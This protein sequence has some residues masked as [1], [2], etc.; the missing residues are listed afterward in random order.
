M[1]SEELQILPVFGIRRDMRNPLWNEFINWLNSF[2]ESGRTAPYGGDFSRYYGIKY[3]HMKG[4]KYTHHSD[5]ESS[6]NNNIITL[7]EWKEN[8]STGKFLD[9]ISNFL[10]KYGS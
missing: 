9:S 2:K 4:K 8:Y 1:D 5:T 7:N 3:N 6:F 10:E